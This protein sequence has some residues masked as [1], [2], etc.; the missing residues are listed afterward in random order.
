MGNAKLSCLLRQSYIQ[1]YPAVTS[2]LVIYHV[3][4][5]EVGITRKD[6][7]HTESDTRGVLII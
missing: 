5:Q 2:A 3:P 6:E 1:I 4:P 7:G